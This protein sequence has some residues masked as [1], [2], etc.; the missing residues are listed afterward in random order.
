MKILIIA[1]DFP[2]VNRIA[3][4]RPYSWAKYWSQQGHEI[5][6]LTGRST[7]APLDFNNGYLEAIQDK[8]HIEVIHYLHIK[9]AQNSSWNIDI[10][11]TKTSSTIYRSLKEGLLRASDVIGAGSLLTASLFWIQ[12]A[13]KKALEIYTKWPFEIMISTYGPP[14]AHIIAGL[15]YPKT[16]AF[17]IADYRDVWDSRYSTQPETGIFRCIQKSLETSL[18]IQKTKMITTIS[19]S[20]A[21]QL[22]MRFDTPVKV[23]ENGFDLDDLKLV[24]KNFQPFPNDKK[25]RLG[26]TGTI[27]PIKR[28]PSTLL[29]A[30]QH[31]I[32]QDIAIKEKIRLVF[33]S[34]DHSEIKRLAKK[35]K[36]EEILECFPYVERAMILQIQRSLDALIFL[37][38]SDPS[39]EGILT[40][41]LFEY[42]YSGTPILSFGAN[43]Q[44]IASKI[45][46]ES[47]TGICLGKSVK[48]TAKVI[49]QLINTRKISINPSTNILNK[50]SRKNLALEMLTEIEK[51]YFLYKNKT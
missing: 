8:V 2:P 44:T 14:A 16:R 43:H 33:Y 6:V 32:N 39:A 48:N 24:N 15:V 26:Y 45:I 27:I 31:L 36:L 10:N 18:M 25:I 7:H 51:E 1:H 23:I 13:Y 11:S 46:E 35:Y 42:L 41:K 4:L 40:G 49:M 20:L 38:W 29:E 12:P 3:A 21:K 28:D 50:Y 17:W 9:S 22:K 47:G 34:A 30:I 5:T 19:D 37:D